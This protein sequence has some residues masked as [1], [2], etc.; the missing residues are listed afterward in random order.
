MRVKGRNHR[1]HSCALKIRQQI[2][3]KF[4]LTEQVTL[5][6]MEDIQT[7]E[8]MN[9]TKILDLKLCVKKLFKG[10][11]IWFIIISQENIIHIHSHLSKI[12]PVQFSKTRVIIHTRNKNF[13]LEGKSEFCLPLPGCQSKTIKGLVKSISQNRWRRISRPDFSGHNDTYHNPSLGKPTCNLE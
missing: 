6:K 3:S 10:C 1:S 12:R 4:M 8:I 9:D 7:K 2:K 5:W 13:G 11:K